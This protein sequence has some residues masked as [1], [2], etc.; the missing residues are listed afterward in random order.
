MLRAFRTSAQQALNLLMEFNP[1]YLL[2]KSNKIKREL[3]WFSQ[4]RL[5]QIG[6]T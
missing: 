6:G 5:K 1:E 2:G 3:P 4:A